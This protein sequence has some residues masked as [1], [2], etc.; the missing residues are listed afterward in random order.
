MISTDRCLSS[1]S[2]RL[3]SGSRYRESLMLLDGRAYSRGGYR[4][5]SSI[6]AMSSCISSLLEAGLRLA[7]YIS[8]CH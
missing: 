8:D 4:D 7:L 6:W 1:I 3:I 2:A 5:F